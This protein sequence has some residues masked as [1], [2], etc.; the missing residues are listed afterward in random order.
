M[1]FFGL[2]VAVID[3]DFAFV[4]VG[5]EL[6]FGAE[7]EVGAVGGERLPMKP[8]GLAAGWVIEPAMPCTSSPFGWW[9][10]IPV[11]SSSKQGEQMFGAAEGEGVKARVGFFEG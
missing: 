4:C 5:L 6:G 2:Q 11:L 10:G 3:R 1:G 9:T 7:D 8:A